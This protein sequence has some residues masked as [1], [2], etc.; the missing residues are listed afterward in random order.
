MASITIDQAIKG[1]LGLGGRV[2]NR[3]VEIMKE[4]AAVRDDGSPVQHKVDGKLGVPRLVDSIRYEH[5][6]FS[7]EYAIGPH[8]PHAEF[9]RYGRGPV[10]PKS[11]KWLHWIEPG[12]A[13]VF[14]KYVGP[15]RPNHFIERTKERLEGEKFNIVE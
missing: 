15:A 6:A 12:G 4:E 2:A 5:R 9:F 8:V 14:K 11:K 13:D 7:R 1:I 3:A 10:T